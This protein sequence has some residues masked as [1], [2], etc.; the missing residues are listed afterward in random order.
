MRIERRGRA[1]GWPDV[2]MPASA[3]DA[4]MVQATALVAPG[5]SSGGTERSVGYG[6]AG[7]GAWLLLAGAWFA[8]AVLL[9]VPELPAGAG[10]FG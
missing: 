8:G 2:R 4:Q 5:Q 1:C 6:L 10:A 3:A 9:P 7:A